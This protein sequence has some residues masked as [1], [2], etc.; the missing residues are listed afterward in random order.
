MSLK[1]VVIL[2]TISRKIVN[3]QELDQNRYPNEFNRCKRR[4]ISK[5]CVVS[6]ISHKQVEGAERVFDRFG[7]ES[8]NIGEEDLLSIVQPTTM[9]NNKEEEGENISRGRRARRPLVADSDQESNDGHDVNSPNE[10]GT[11]NE[12]QWIKLEQF[13]A[14]NLEFFG[15]PEDVPVVTLALASPVLTVAAT[16]LDMN[17]VSHQ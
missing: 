4:W 1:R 3:A 16:A 7:G 2:R 10:D 15:P 5:Y 6:G 9:N 14:D 12:H 8:R 17:V 11:L 13:E